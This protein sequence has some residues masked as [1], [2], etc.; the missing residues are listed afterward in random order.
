MFVSLR[1]TNAATWAVGPEADQEQSKVASGSPAG[2]LGLA[3]AAK[4]AR[5]RASRTPFWQVASW[6]GV[7]GSLRPALRSPP[8][9]ARG[10][11]PV[12]RPLTQQPR[13]GC[14]AG[15]KQINP[16]ERV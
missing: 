5:G 2:G 10:D 14:L 12:R 13:W 11:E 6:R 15:E 8:Q 3:P 1:Y 9:R 7:N 16:C 4:G